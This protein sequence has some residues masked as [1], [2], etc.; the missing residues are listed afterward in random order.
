MPPKK[1]S[2]EIIF[3]E[4]AGTYA[5]RHHNQDQYLE[6]I[7]CFCKPFASTEAPV[8]LELGCGPGNL[9][10]YLLRT[11]PQAQL[12]GI[13]VAPGMIALATEALPQARFLVADVRDTSLW[14]EQIH[15]LVAAFVTPYLNPDETRQLIRAAGAKIPVGGML[16][17]STMDAYETQMIQVPVSTNEYYADLCFYAA[18]DLKT[19]FME[20]GFQVIQE[21]TFEQEKSY[22][23]GSVDL[24]M[25][26]EKI[27]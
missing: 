24:L 1:T 4:F 12:T 9:S 2:P 11:L 20:S 16:Y 18:S 19:W 14:P 25:V 7:H 15:G 3:H 17:L 23:P 5:G 27:R 22:V 10:A 13:D 6:A 26:A 8:L 21:W